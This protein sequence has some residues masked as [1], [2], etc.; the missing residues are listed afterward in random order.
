MDL[1]NSMMPPH[2]TAKSPVCPSST[3][4]SEQA[5]QD[6]ST[7]QIYLI[8]LV[9]CL[10]A[11]QMMMLIA[12]KQVMT[13][14]PLPLV[15]C[16]CQFLV[17][18]LSAGA[19]IY[20][21]TCCCNESTASIDA[22]PKKKTSWTFY[23]PLSLSWTL[24]FVLFNASATFMS[25]SHVNLIRCG[26][27]LATVLVGFVL[28]GKRYAGRVLITLVPVLGGVW[29][30]SPSS[31]AAHALSL[32]GILLAGLSN[33]CFCTRPFVLHAMKHNQQ[34]ASSVSPTKIIPNGNGHS[35]TQKPRSQ[36]QD[37]LY[38]FFTVT[39]LAAFFILPGLVWILE[40]GMLERYYGYLY[41][42]VLYEHDFLVSIVTACLGFFA[43][44]YTQLR[45]MSLVSPLAFSILT[46]VIKAV[47]IVLCSLYFGDPLG[48]WQ[49][50][51][52]VTTTSG[53]YWFTMTKTAPPSSKKASVLPVHF[54]PDG[55]HA[56]KS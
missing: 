32:N 15:L 10:I 21:S 13:I 12:T 16:E 11:T 3:P 6:G 19:L 34:S 50:V 46:P 30:A 54:F 55:K 2:G 36:E 28:F 51:G 24:G 41:S 49:F 48:I 4:S 23:L 47:M 56:H 8:F 17:S 5:K 44:Q 7:S 42:K 43:Y 25:P 18:C 29:L 9:M 33:I 14:V 31:K 45:V 37:D 35:C 1:G 52:V 27:P 40:G 26:E 22:N 53:G 20:L 39:A 38:I